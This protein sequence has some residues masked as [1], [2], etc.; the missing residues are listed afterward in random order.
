MFWTVLIALTVIYAA[1]TALATQ[2]MKQ[3]SAS[4]ST[5]RS[6]GKVAIGKQKNAFTSGSIVILLIDEEGIIQDG[7]KIT[8]ITVFSSFHQFTDLNGMTLANV[9]PATI[10]G[11]RSFRNAVG[12]AKNNY[13]TIISGGVPVEPLTPLMKLID[14]LDMRI[15]RHDDGRRTSKILLQ[16]E[17]RAA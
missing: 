3:F 13:L 16:R 9:N 10:R 6:R 1:N 15:G 2:Q 4:Y 5:L 8:G 11:A 7:R 17:E 12:N 14:R